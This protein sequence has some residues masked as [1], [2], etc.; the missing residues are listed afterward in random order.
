MIARTEEAPAKVNLCL[1]VG[2]TRERDGRHELVTVFEPLELA[3][4]VR[5]GPAAGD[6]DEVVCPGVRRPNLA[7]DALALFREATG[8]DGPPVRVTIRK[9]IPVAGG[10]AGGSADAAAAL[11]LAARASGLGD[12][13]LLL[14]LAFRLGADVPGQVR[15]RR[16]LAL[17]AGERLEELDPPPEPYGVL[18]L[19]SA[20]QLS[21]GA[22]FAEADRLGHVRDAAELEAVAQDVRAGHVPPV[23]DLEDAARSLL[24]S[25]DDALNAA[26]AAGADRAMVSGSGPTVVGF[27]PTPREAERAAVLLAGRPGP[28]PVATTPAVVPARHHGGEP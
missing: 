7:H 23:N 9:R 22:V 16:L 14:D 27:F 6:A 28:A 18:V 13:D 19:P 2:P 3:D 12:E 15:P 17:G 20:E 25:I 26:L 10:M 11:R 1:L 5:L 21:T 4:D 24:P 8:W